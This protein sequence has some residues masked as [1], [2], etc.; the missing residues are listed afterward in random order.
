[1]TARPDLRASGSV[2]PPQRRRRDGRGVSKATT[3]TDH[4][5]RQGERDM[6]G[7]DRTSHRSDVS[8][9][10]TRA[11]T[12]ARGMR[13]YWVSP[14][15]QAQN[16]FSPRHACARRA[17]KRRRRQYITESNTTRTC[18]ATQTA[19]PEAHAC[20]RQ[21]A[22]RV[23]RLAYTRA[24]CEFETKGEKNLW[25]IL[26]QGPGVKE[27]RAPGPEGPWARGCRGLGP[28]TRGAPTNAPI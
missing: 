9:S 14:D 28:G 10:P 15:A 13:V 20:K 12:H 8:V 25:P 27:G 21:C 17:R 26:A 2:N 23:V 3:Q 1:M 24:H 7:C 18:G 22:R 19:G 4:A 11:R 6:S 5:T 16:G